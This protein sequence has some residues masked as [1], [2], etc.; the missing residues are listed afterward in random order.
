MADYLPDGSPSPEL[1]KL[2]QAD[3]AMRKAQAA[4][5][6]KEAPGGRKLTREMYTRSPEFISKFGADFAKTQNNYERDPSGD[7]AAIDPVNPIPV[8]EA[9]PLPVRDDSWLLELEAQAA[10]EA[11]LA[12]QQSNYENT[13]H[14][15]QRAGDAMTP[16]QYANSP[17]GRALMGE[18]ADRQVAVEELH[19]EDPKYGRD[20]EPVVK[21]ITEAAA[22]NPTA[23]LAETAAGLQALSPQE[24]TGQ[25][26]P[27]LTSN[28][29]NLGRD[30]SKAGAAASDA[31]GQAMQPVTDHV[32]YVNSNAG[33]N[34]PTVEDTTSN[35]IQAVLGTL[36]GDASS[37]QMQRIYSGNERD[38]NVLS[39]LPLDTQTR[40]D[41][42]ARQETVAPAVGP[43]G[44]GID[45]TKDSLQ[46]KNYAPSSINGYV[47][48]ALGNPNGNEM[49]N[50]IAPTPGQEPVDGLVPEEVKE[51]E[52]A[53]AI[54]LKNA[55]EVKIDTV[56]E[57][58]KKKIPAGA[59][60]K[61]V[62]TAIIETFQEHIDSEPALWETII[63][64]GRAM[65]ALAGL[66]M[67]LI[68][69][70]EFGD[71]VS[72]AAIGAGASQD[73][74]NQEDQRQ[75]DN[76]IALMDANTRAEELDIKKAGLTLKE[77]EFVQKVKKEGDAKLL[78]KKQVA[79]LQR[80][81]YAVAIKQ[82]KDQQSVEESIEGADFTSRGFETANLLLK[83]AG[84]PLIDPGSFS[85]T[86]SEEP[87][88]PQKTTD[89]ATVSEKWKK[90]T[91]EA[92]AIF[93][94]TY[95]LTMDEA[96]AKFGGGE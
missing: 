14:W 28:I 22:V 71:A 75:R 15:K 38:I 86:D 80:E 30:I 88:T 70:E 83:A 58:A 40:R 47:E 21:A 31:I 27:G 13:L 89:V 41:A 73:Y 1:I 29:P 39:E 54:I 44:S 79:D 92:K 43:E 69:G 17:R 64:D 12:K 24:E 77:K 48:D 35:V 90:S 82:L 4:F 19:P 87:S 85:L 3:W 55:E 51:M 94:K 10:D 91:P 78:T 59:G 60:E 57:D 66:T 49:V 16:A 33:W 26:M 93:A 84:V 20:L 81:A 52:V 63:G 45:V 23:T 9:G 34:K 50:A 56:V 76:Q 53:E 62:E 96:E 7:L 72:Y 68:S 95:N 67:A 65:G 37:D 25:R 5:E 32:D 74:M 2:R 42:R 18:G 6:D 8:P 46:D 61:E 11:M 36:N